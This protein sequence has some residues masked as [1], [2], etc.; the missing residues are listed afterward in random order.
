M[1]HATIFL[2]ST[3][4]K[5]FRRAII[6]PAVMPKF[7]ILEGF[8]HFR[9]VLLFSRG[10][11]IFEGFRYFRGVSVIFDGFNYFRGVSFFP[12]GFREL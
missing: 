9:G 11:V 8:C 7:V 10:F 3:F 12:R 1:Q 5:G 6:V 4:L 2:N